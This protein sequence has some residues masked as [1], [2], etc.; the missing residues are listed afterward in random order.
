[1]EVYSG[2]SRIS[3]RGR[4]R[5]RDKGGKLSHPLVRHAAMLRRKQNI[6]GEISQREQWPNAPQI[7]QWKYTDHND[8]FY[9]YNRLVIS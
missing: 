5:G 8:T 3:Q 7:R 6:R 9:S 1:M 2:V 4:P